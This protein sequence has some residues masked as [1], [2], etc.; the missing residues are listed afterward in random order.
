MRRTEIQFGNG[1]RAGCRDGDGLYVG[2]ELQIELL[3]FHEF[4]WGANLGTS[5]IS[6]FRVQHPFRK[7]V[8]VRCALVLGWGLERSGGVT[9]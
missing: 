8:H 3:L 2:I 9:G 4:R 1:R 5:C 6:I 7:A